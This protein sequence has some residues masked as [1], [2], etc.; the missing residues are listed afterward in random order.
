MSQPNSIV[1]INFAAVSNLAHTLTD[2]KEQ[3][4][5]QSL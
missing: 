5:L 3:Q 2:I 4:T 1:G